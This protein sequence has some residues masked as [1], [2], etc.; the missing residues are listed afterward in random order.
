MSPKFVNLITAVEIHRESLVRFGGLDG[1]RSQELLESALAQPQM[2]FGGTFLHDDV[3]EMAAAYLFHLVK[4]LPFLDGNKRT[5][6]GVAL[7]FLDQNGVSIE[8]PSSRLYD[9]TMAVA[10]GT[11]DKAGLTAILRELAR[12]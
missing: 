10:E 9:I 3:F 7:A 8:Q 2:T 12:S 11:L 1:V 5:G 4:N 6:L